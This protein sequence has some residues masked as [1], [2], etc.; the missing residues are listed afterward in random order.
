MPVWNNLSDL[1]LLEHLSSRFIVSP[2]Y[3]I[4]T[5]T[6]AE[7]EKEE[8]EERDQ[9]KWTRSSVILEG[10]AGGGALVAARRRLLIHPRKNEGR[11]PQER[12]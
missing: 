5:P 10:L 4:I 11:N 1:D 6:A 8:E 3:N 9:T 7:R 12:N 2:T